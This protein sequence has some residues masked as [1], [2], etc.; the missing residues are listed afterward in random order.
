MTLSNLEPDQVEFMI[1][2]VEKASVKTQE[3]QELLAWLTIQFVHQTKGDMYKDLVNK[4][5]YST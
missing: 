1:G 4:L 2:C 3:Q 5:G